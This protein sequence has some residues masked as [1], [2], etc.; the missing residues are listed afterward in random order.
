M[1]SDHTHRAYRRLGGLRAP[2]AFRHR[3]VVFPALLCSNPLVSSPPLLCPISPLP[4]PP[5]V[6]SPSIPY[7]P[8]IS[9]LGFGG[10]A[11]PV[12]IPLVD[13][14]TCGSLSKSESF[15]LR[16]EK[17]PIGDLTTIP[18]PHDGFTLYRR[19]VPAGVEI[20]NPKTAGE[21]PGFWTPAQH[22]TIAT[23]APEDMIVADFYSSFHPEAAWTNAFI[24]SVL[25]PNGA[26]RTL[27]HGIAAI[28]RD[29][30][31]DGR[32]YAK[33]YEKEGIKGEEKNISWIPFETEPIRAV[34]ERDFG[35][36]F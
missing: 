33:L 16:R 34:L 17:M 22:L 23:V 15:L 2:M 10:G 9:S 21:G 1:E 31:K 6:P 20:E 36:E 7:S 28:E 27:V 25:L 24:A 11:S 14:A 3:Y 8:G 4:C 13:G 30:P 29:A 35:F 32:K 19:V 5:S 18:D 12:P 26:R